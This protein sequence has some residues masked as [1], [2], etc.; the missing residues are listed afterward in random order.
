MIGSEFLRLLLC[1]FSLGALVILHG[2]ASIVAE[3]LPQQR[4]KIE[5]SVSCDKNVPTQ[6]KVNKEICKRAKDIV[7]EKLGFKKAVVGFDVNG[8]GKL[9]LAGQFKDEDE[10]TRAYSAVQWLVGSKNLSPVT[11]GYIKVE[12]WQEC[13][14]NKLSG[15][16]CKDTPLEG[17]ELWNKSPGP[18]RE[19]YALVIGVGNFKNAIKPLKYAADDASAVAEYLKDPNMGGFLP[20]NVTLLINEDAT[21][22]AIL[23]QMNAIKQKAGADDLVIIY[24]S[25]HGAPPDMFKFVNI[26]T[27]DTDYLFGERHESELT[28]DERRLMQQALWETSV[29]REVLLD[30]MGYLKSKRVLLVLDVCYSGNAFSDIPGFMASGDFAREEENFSTGYSPDQ[31]IALL[32]AKDMVMAGKNGQFTESK[33]NKS[34]S[35]ASG[36]EGKIRR[37]DRKPRGNPS[38][39]WGKVIISASSSNEKSWEPSGD[40]P[41]VLSPDG[42]SNSFFTHYFIRSLRKTGGRI[43]DSYMLT[44]PLVVK[45]VRR[46][47]GEKQHPQAGAFPN[48]DSWNFSIGANR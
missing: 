4:V 28:E 43:Q 25:S 42:I 7:R 44:F 31:L 10:I 40:D 30:F 45:E 46:S 16:S 15:R 22:K 24:M 20:A 14:Q 19:R 34:R 39:S 41:Q 37:S 12:A 29:S 38:K 3:V 11:P 48:N 6:G 13:L 17:Y 27:Y 26:V 47:K 21:R 2:C 23:D 32:G 18:V 9:Q 33:P 8:K 5:D 35:L 1:R 36:N